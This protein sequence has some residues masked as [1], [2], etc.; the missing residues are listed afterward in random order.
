MSDKLDKK[1][2]KAP[3]AFQAAGAQ[4]QGWLQAN[5]KTV[6]LGVAGVLVAGLG[7]GI[8]NW[9]GRRSDEKSARELG[10]ALKPLER[11][12]DVTGFAAAGATD[13]STVPFKSQAE[14]DQA[15]VESLEAFRNGHSGSPAAATAG[16]PL[17]QSQLRLGKYDEALAAFDAFLASAKAGDPLRSAALEGRGYAYEGKGQLDKAYEAFAQLSKENSTPFLEGMGPYHQARVLLAQ[18]KK[19]DAAKG[20]AEVSAKF[21][22]SAAGRMAQERVSALVAQGVVPPVVAAGA[23][24]AGT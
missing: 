6:A 12:V 16:L 10:A 24:D 15:V 7:V 3:D 21:P 5:E 4:A 18:G 13:P 1:E 2:L 17:A 8:V 19:D 11:G 20:F 23:A 14:K 9:A 22:K